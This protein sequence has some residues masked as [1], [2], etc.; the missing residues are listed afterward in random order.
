MHQPS[1]S[2]KHSFHRSGI[3]VFILATVLAGLPGGCDKQEAAKHEQPE[4]KE[5][6]GEETKSDEH[7][8]EVTLS[9]RAVEKYGI[10]V[11]QA[12]QV[13]LAP[14]VV[15]PGRITFNTEAI[16]HVGVVMRGRVVD[17]KVKRG[18]RVKKGAELLIVESP[19]LGEAQNDYLQKLTTLAIAKPSAELAKNAYQRLKGLYETSKGISLTDLEKREAELKTAE[20]ALQ[21]AA[22]SVTASENKLHLLGM[23]QAAVEQLAKS[24]EIVPR[25]AVTAPIGGQITERE[26]TLGELVSPEKEAVLVIADTSTLWVVADIP[27]ARLSEIQIGSP[28]RVN[29]AALG[30][31]VVKGAVSLIDPSLD[32]NTRTARVRIGV[33]NEAGALRPGMFAEVEVVARAKG[34]A[35]AKAVLAIPEEAVQ[36]IEGVTAVFTPVKGEPRTFAKHPVKIGRPVSGMVPVLAGLKD[37]DELVTAGSFILKADLGKEAVEED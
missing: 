31:D 12:K 6:G 20:G 35:D 17:L 10:R 36:T 32:Q 23:N 19:E 16:A 21:S 26:V 2:Q 22:A 13:T 4:K 1:R 25:Y 37:G 5:G 7:K 33:P 34:D 27:E 24:K 11:E 8:E 9:D 29:V 14:T 28:A 15:A 3:A 30:G 18:D